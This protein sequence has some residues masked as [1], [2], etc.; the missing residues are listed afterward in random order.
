M[1]C[2]QIFPWVGRPLASKNG[3]FLKM[4]FSRKLMMM[5]MIMV[6]SRSLHPFIQNSKGL[7]T[8]ISKRVFLPFNIFHR[9][10]IASDRFRWFVKCTF[11][12]R[13]NLSVPRNYP[14]LN[15]FGAQL[16]NC[17]ILNIFGTKLKNLPIGSVR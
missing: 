7:P 9:Q 1:I 2:P 4:E 14:I 11:D 15:I 16:K 12:G 10:I 8:S 13:W 3:K 17:P 5:V 6:I